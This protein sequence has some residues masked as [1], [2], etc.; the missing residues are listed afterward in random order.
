MA[1]LVAADERLGAEG[2]AILE[3]GVG[4]PAAPRAAAPG[5]ARSPAAT[6]CSGGGRR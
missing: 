1:E 6:V 2:A 5:R 3:P 4:L